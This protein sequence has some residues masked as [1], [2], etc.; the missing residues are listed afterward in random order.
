MFATSLNWLFTSS[1]ALLYITVYTCF[2][3]VLCFTLITEKLLL[4]VVA[5]IAYD[6]NDV[7]MMMMLCVT[8]EA[9]LKTAA[10]DM[11]YVLCFYI[12]ALCGC[13]VV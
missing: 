13:L 9:T 11:F 12:I 2:I 7:K 1:Y 3:S 10:K 4:V 8:R 5:M 6:D